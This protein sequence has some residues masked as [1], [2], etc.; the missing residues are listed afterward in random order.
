M[1]EFS[2]SLF[3]Q[4]S[5]CSNAKTV[6]PCQT[7]HSSQPSHFVL[8]LD[9]AMVHIGQ[10]AHTKCMRKLFDYTSQALLP[11]YICCSWVTHCNSCIPNRQDAHLPLNTKIVMHIQ[12]V[13]SFCLKERLVNFNY[14]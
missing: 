7:D 10:T 11:P 3:V 5:V 2:T 13:M 1:H 4:A 14:Y 9:Y 6:F 8:P 12:A